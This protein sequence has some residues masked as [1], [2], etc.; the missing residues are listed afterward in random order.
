MTRNDAQTYT[1]PVD[2]Y[3]S[4]RCLCGH[5]V[6]TDDQPGDRCRWEFV[7]AGCDCTDHRV[8]GGKA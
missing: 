5:I 6:Y 2:P 3:A 8:E 7:G 1:K 4:A